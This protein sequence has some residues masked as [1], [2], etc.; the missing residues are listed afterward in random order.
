[1]DARLVECLTSLNM[2]S[3][4][5]FTGS[6]K[7]GL[8]DG[9]ISVNTLLRLKELAQR[10]QRPEDIVAATPEETYATH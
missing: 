7:F 6:F 4:Y 10:V 8:T 3:L 1:M 9:K 5:H 2:L